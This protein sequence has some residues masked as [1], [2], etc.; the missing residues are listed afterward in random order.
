MKKFN[1]NQQQQA[2]MKQTLKKRK[3][4]SAL[5]ALSLATII[6]LFAASDSFGVPSSEEMLVDDPSYKL[7]L[8]AEVVE[9]LEKDDFEFG[10][11]TTEY[12]KI[13]DAQNKLIK[14]VTL[15]ADEV[16]ENSEV[17]K[18]IYTSEYLTSYGNTSIYRLVQ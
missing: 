14:V 11:E 8:I 16:V 13:F 18:L 2:V 12:I 10:F 1:T 7:E 5:M 6:T 9:E 15:K 4:I 3:S 17:K